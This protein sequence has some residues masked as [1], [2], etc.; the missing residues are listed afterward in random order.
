[1]R[2]MSPLSIRCLIHGAELPQQ[3]L[4]TDKLITVQMNTY[5]VGNSKCQ[6]SSK[7]RALHGRVQGKR[8]SEGFSVR[9]MA[10]K[11]G[12]DKFLSI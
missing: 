3:V 11:R 1:M 2:K 7:Q 6:A 5:F 10:G 9:L 12:R 8:V 4:A